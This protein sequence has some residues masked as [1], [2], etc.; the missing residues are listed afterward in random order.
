MGILSRFR[1]IM[2]SNMNALLDKAEDP[3]KTIDN[4]MRNV[5]IDLGKVKAETA[6]VLA[7]ERRTKRTL[8]DCQAEI[9]KLQHYAEKAV[10]AGNEG[11]ARKFLE[12][13]V[14]LTEK[15][16]GCKPRMT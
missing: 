12:K 9:S 11:D 2:A 8:D 5:N 10:E 3:E 1:D 4:F 16:R 13:K 14:L 15:E 7:D 6:S